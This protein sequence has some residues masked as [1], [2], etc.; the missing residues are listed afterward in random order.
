MRI[1]MGD[2]GRDD[3]GDSTSRGAGPGPGTSSEAGREGGGEACNGQC[4][5]EWYIISGE[6]RT[7]A[8]SLGCL[9]TTFPVRAR[10]PAG[11]RG[12]SCLRSP[13]RL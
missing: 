11:Q 5:L 6:R 13:L 1:E 4:Q 8:T 3:T 12:S 2:C 7:L 10:S 9:A